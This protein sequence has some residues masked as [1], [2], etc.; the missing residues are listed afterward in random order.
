MSEG[1]FGIYIHWP[2]CQSKCPY[3][4]FNSHVSAEVDQRLWARAFVSELERYH[5]ETPDRIVNSIF[6]GGGTPSL[7]APEL[8][9]T[10][11]LCIVEN[12]KIARDVEITLEANPSSVEAGRF[13]D[14]RGAGINR[15]SLGIQ[16]L[17]DGDLKRLGRL[18][19]ANEALA[20]IE[21]AQQTFQRVSI[22]LIYARQDQT[23]DAW[24]R[25]LANALSLGTEHL[26]LY[27]LTIE[28]G[29]AF[30]KRHSQGHLAGLPDDD[31][32]ANLYSLT[33]SMC[34]AAGLPAY[35]VSNHARPNAQSRHNMIYWQGGEYLGVGPGAHGRLV[36]NG[37][38]FATDTKLS[39]KGW[40]SAAF[41]GNAENSRVALSSQEQALEYL[42]MSLR[43]TE[44]ANLD[45]LH[46]I[47]STLINK[48]KIDELQGYDLI[49]CKAGVLR[50]TISGR[51]VLNAVIRELVTD[52]Q[53]KA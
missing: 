1:G 47:S 28:Q 53:T 16:S 50:A 9:E 11:I 32:S 26:S 10:A 41:A 30:G 14:Y 19:T 42:M 37:E 3:C 12:W 33:Q 40:L 23:E 24:K 7:M 15:V 8:L 17:N 39:P 21:V 48:R 5:K 36:R 4:D 35:E 51:L 52:R 49:E 13:E 43:L 44:G 2:F 18:H 29:T 27:Q 38:R 20:A 34:E 25:E 46:Y 31:L 22:D 45:R 6:F